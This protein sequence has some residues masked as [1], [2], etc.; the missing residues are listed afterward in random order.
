LPLSFKEE[1]ESH[2]LKEFSSLIFLRISKN[3][4]VRILIMPIVLLFDK[5]V[6]LEER[7]RDILFY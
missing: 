6:E 7:E 2:L 4:F 1:A 3:L 5:V